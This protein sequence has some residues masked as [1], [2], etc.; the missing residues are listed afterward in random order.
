MSKIII[1][2]MSLYIV[3][4]TNFHLTSLPARTEGGV[5][6]VMGEPVSILRENN[7]Q[8]WTYRKNDCTQMVFFDDTNTVVDWY[9]IG[10]C[11]EEE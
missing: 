1:I 8:M 3:A 11:S 6:S 9:D 7:R 4:C 5:R 2:V 10:N